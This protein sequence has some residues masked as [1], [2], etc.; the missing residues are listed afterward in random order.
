MRPKNHS[1]NDWFRKHTRTKLTPCIG[2][3]WDE[4]DSQFSVKN[5]VWPKNDSTHDWLREHTRT[6]LT[7]YID[8]VWNVGV[9]KFK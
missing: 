3:V 5:A 2:D 9:S 8:D 7:N 1:K 6:K 4:G